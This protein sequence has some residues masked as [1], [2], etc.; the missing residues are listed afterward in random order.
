VIYALAADLVMLL[1]ACFIMFVLFGSLL[2]LRSRLFILLHLP[3]AIWGF[4][5]EWNGWVCPLTPL[6]NSFRALANQT[7]Y[8]GGFIDHY[9]LPLIYPDALTR[10][11]QY[12]LALAVIILNLMLYS[13]CLYRTLKKQQPVSSTKPFQP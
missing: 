5:S 2:C 4:F 13:Y 8:N 6:E 12:V 9:L 1:H 7:P 3:A 10:D 11:I